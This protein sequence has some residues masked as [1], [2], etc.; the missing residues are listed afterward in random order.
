MTIFGAPLYVH[1]SVLVLAVVLFALWVRQP[2]HAIECVC[3]YF[4]LILLHE[5]GHAVVVHRLGYSV[6]GIYLSGI[7]GLCQYEQPDTLR[8]DCLIAWGGVLAQLAV[9]I[10]VIA[11]AQI[12]GLGALPF[13]GII[14]GTFGYFSLVMLL[15][16]LTPAGGLDGA[17]TWRLFPILLAD[18]RAHR[19]TKKAARDLFKRLR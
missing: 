8:E 4:G 15:F 3:C 11:L 2:L 6:V 12:P 1:W 19:S 13:V 10:P 5:L 17:K 9:A 16:N 7:H 18:L 14:I